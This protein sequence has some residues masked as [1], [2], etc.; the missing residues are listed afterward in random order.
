MKSLCL[1]VYTKRMQPTTFFDNPSYFR[2]ASLVWK[3]GWKDIRTLTVV[4][5]KNSSL[6]F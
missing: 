5:I 4:N 2:F 1:L 6:D 3:G